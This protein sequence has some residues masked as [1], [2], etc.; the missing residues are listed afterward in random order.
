MDSTD[1]VD[2]TTNTIT[3]IPAMATSPLIM[4]IIDSRNLKKETMVHYF[5]ILIA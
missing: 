4:P 1:T 2:I 5:R 3:T